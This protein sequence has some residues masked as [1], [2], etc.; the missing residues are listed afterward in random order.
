MSVESV[1]VEVV[2]DVTGIDKT[3]DYFVPEEFWDRIDIG[4]KV[5]VN[6]NGR[7]IGGWVVDLRRETT[8]HDE[9]KPILK[10]SGIGPDS[11]MIELCRW[12]ARRWCVTKL[13]PF[14]I[15]ASPNSVIT[16]A[17]PPRRSRVET[18]PVSP[19]ARSLLAGGGGV[20]RLAPTV[21][22]LPAVLSAASLG[23]TVVVCSSVDASKVLAARVRRTG[24]TVA[25][26]PHDWALA[27]GGVDVT[28]GARSAAFAP[29]PNMA[30]AV[31]LDEHE[32]SLQEER[33]PTWHARDVLAERCRRNQV[34]LMAISAFPTLVGSFGRT[35]LAP[36]LERERAGW[37]EIRVVDRSEEPVWSRSL[38]SSEV[39]GLAREAHLR[40]VCVVNTKGLARLLACRKCDALIRCEDCSSTLVEVESSRLDCLVCG[41]LRPRVC[42][43]C[44]STSISRLRPGVTRLREELEKAA[45][46]PVAVVESSQTDFDDS[47]HDVFIGTSAS[48]HRVRRANVVAFLDFDREL[49]APR[50]QAHE[51]AMALLVDAARMVGPRDR[52]GLVLLQTTLWDHDV[53]RAAVEA[54]M[55]IL[56]DSES[57][58]RESLNLPPFSALAVI[59]GEGTDECLRL[60]KGT[61][62]IAAVRHNEGA[63]VRARDHE[64]LSAVWER[65]PHMA[66]SAVRIEVDPT[67]A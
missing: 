59:S 20:L 7:R 27:R 63:L 43:I 48:L 46:R 51:R 21:D 47:T 55:S 33:M 35:T 36:P 32:E 41:K 38:L 49:L 56:I 6:L 26:M 8:Q 14:L 60:L 42:A 5:R 31:L 29:C 4:S 11:E 34:P 39:I 15:A 30:C 18:G 17:A 53:V 1:V 40:V 62:G 23:P 64:L 3:F 52:K 44:S 24:L 45:N 57:H 22:Q 10:W 66:R 37:P 61:P 28:I 13:R 65:L 58:R 50:F 67:S 19:A 54:N 9:L 16:R 2:P 12:A 25:L